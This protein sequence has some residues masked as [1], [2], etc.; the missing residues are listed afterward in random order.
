MDHGESYL[1]LYVFHPD[2]QALA[3]LQSSR[4]HGSPAC[5]REYHWFE[6]IASNELPFARP[7]ALPHALCSLSHVG[8]VLHAAVNRC[9][10]AAI[11]KFR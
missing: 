4:R 2:P 11:D 5:G 7:F 1:P 6:D 10:S 3:A 9:P 8:F